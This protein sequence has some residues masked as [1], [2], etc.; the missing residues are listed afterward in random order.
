MRYLGIDYGKNHIGMAISEGFLAQPYPGKMQ[1]AKCKMQ[2]DNSKLK[3]IK[4]IINKE[5][6]EKI[7]IG[8][9]EGK[10][11]ER[12]KEFAEGMKRITGLPVIYYDET[13][14]SQEAI[15]KMIEA[16]KKKKFKKEREHNIAAC[17]ILQD[18]LDSHR[19]RN[20][21]L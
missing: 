13:L 14:T 1:N 16:G 4:E 21:G 12:T 17:I 20:S 15:K 18:Y 8:I 2:N 11:A 3:I 9:S 5:G 6:I 19:V 7:I 10:M